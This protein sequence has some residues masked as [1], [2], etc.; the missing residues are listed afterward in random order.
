MHELVLIDHIILQAKK[1]IERYLDLNDNQNEGDSEAKV[2]IH[3]LKTFEGFGG[4]S[5]SM[6]AL[7][8]I[9]PTENFL[10][11]STDIIGCMNEDRQLC[12]RTKYLSQKL[13]K[14]ECVPWEFLKQGGKKVGHD[15]LNLFNT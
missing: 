6:D 5:Y 8:R 12:K 2:V 15:C 13:D 9:S 4:G 14:C 11:L 10:R 3:T 7:K 1:T